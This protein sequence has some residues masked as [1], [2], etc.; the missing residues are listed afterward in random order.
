MARRIPTARLLTLEQG[1]HLGLGNH[2][3][4]GAALRDFLDKVLPTR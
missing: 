2:P 1:G 3:E 4:V